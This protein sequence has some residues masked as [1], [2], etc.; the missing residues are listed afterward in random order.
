MC[1]QKAP[2]KRVW[3]PFI[4]HAAQLC[5]GLG[6]ENTDAAE[7]RL[8]AP[9]L[10]FPS[11]R[12]PLSIPASSLLPFPYSSRSRSCQRSSSGPRLLPSLVPAEC[13][14]T[15]SFCSSAQGLPR[16]CLPGRPR[17]ARPSGVCRACSRST[18][19][20]VVAVCQIDLPGSYLRRLIPPAAA[21]GKRARIF[22]VPADF[23]FACKN[24]FKTTR[25]DFFR[26]FFFEEKLLKTGE[27][28]TKKSAEKSA[29]EIRGTLLD[30]R[31]GVSFDGVKGKRP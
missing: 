11:F 1:F 6:R 25:A 20:F 28:C 5:I 17:P 29:D 4:P 24:H 19:A 26:G 22:K 8:T 27:V 3:S 31:L 10:R 14:C 2:S 16:S 15:F 23:F 12:L 7:S 30:M 13:A 9:T 21:G 18:Y